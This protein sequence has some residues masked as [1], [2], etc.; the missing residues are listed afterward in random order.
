M[1]KPH[2]NIDLKEIQKVEL[3]CHLELSYRKSTLLEWA[4]EDGDFSKDLDQTH[5]EDKYL[6][7]SPMTDLPSVLHKFLASRDRLKSLERIERLTFEVC[8]DMYLVSNVRILELRYAPSFILETYPELGGENILR[9]I[10]KGCERAEAKYPIATGIICLLQRIK[11]FNENDYWADFAIDH[12]DVILGLDLADDETNYPPELFS[13]IFMKAKSQGMGI[14]VHAGEPATPEA[15]TNILTSIE[16]LGADRIGHG[17]QAIHD[18]KV[19]DKLVETKTVLELCPTSN[20]LTQAVKSL[21]EH[22]LHKLYDLGV[23]TTINTDD[24]GVMN[25]DL[26]KEYHVAHNIL[27]MPIKKLIQTNE[28][29]YE[30]SFICK[31]KKSRVWSKTQ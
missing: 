28:W 30:S 12:K 13:S 6:I 3:H 15:P 22:P 16:Y 5:F 21:S 2:S 25:T 27:E 1:F 17:V 11:P 19:I 7:L 31:T 20:Y 8:E 18:S 9:A 10:I 29:A 24:P 26:M 23:R 4:I 14:T